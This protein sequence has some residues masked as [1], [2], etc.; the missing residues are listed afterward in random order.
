MTF[1][2]YPDIRYY[3]GSYTKDTSMLIA[4]RVTPESIP[5]SLKAVNFQSKILEIEIVNSSQNYELFC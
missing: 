2:G 1:I 5:I 3:L 4:S